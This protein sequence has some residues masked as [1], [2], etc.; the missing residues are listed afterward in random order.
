M[1]FESKQGIIEFE[2]VGVNEDDWITIKS[3]SVSFDKCSFFV[4]AFRR[5]YPAFNLLGSNDVE[6]FD[7]LAEACGKSPTFRNW[8]ASVSIKYSDTTQTPLFLKNRVAPDEYKVLMDQVLVIKNEL[9]QIV[10]S[11]NDLAI[12]YNRNLTRLKEQEDR[13]VSRLIGQ[14]STLKILYLNSECLPFSIQL[15]IQGY[16]P[17]NVDTDITT[18]KRRLTQEYL[19]KFKIALL[20]LVKEKPEVDIDALLDEL[21]VK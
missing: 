9:S 6:K 15:K 16:N 10:K 20:D 21:A 3:Q 7:F 11:R 14:N 17:Q 5:D 13:I 1:K 8:F 12:E 19:A 18:S 2:E 4:D